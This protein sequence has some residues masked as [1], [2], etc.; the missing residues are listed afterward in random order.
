MFPSG[1]QVRSASR[2]VLVEI[3][4]EGWT[5]TQQPPEFSPSR[6]LLPRGFYFYPR[7]ERKR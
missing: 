1:I 2:L 4:P 3:G 5:P 7:K 6:L